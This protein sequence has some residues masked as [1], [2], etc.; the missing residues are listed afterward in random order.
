MLHLEYQHLQAKL[1]V[2]KKPQK[3]VRFAGVRCKKILGRELFCRLQISS[4]ASQ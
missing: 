3:M 2:D 1:F 4:I